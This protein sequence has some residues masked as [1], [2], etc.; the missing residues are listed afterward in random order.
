MELLQKFPVIFVAIL[1]SIRAEEEAFDLSFLG[2]NL[3]ASPDMKVGNM[4]NEKSVNEMQENPEEVG[5]Y[6][7]GDL[8]VPR[9]AG[10]NGMKQEYYRWQDGVVPYEIAGRFSEYLIIA[11]N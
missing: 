9:S 1:T 11:I 8:L 10:K 5:S 7:Q 6:V 2:E 4:L 3:F